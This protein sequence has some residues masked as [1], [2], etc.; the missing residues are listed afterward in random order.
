MKLKKFST[1]QM[2]LSALFIALI[3]VGAY[4]KVQ[5]GIIPFSLQMMFVFLTGQLLQPI[6]AAGTLAA[7]LF[8]G[9]IGLP[10]FSGGG[11]LGYVLQ[12]SFGYIPGFLVMAF[13][14]S[15]ISHRGAPSLLKN[16]VANVCGGVAVYL[17]GLG[18]YFCLN[19]FY[20][21]KVVELSKMLIYCWVIFIPSDM[22]AL[23]LTAFLGLRL[24]RYMPK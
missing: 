24:R 3:T 21:G 10:V 5:V 12:P 9:L 22:I 1:K 7:Y 13:L 6:W 14:I 8:M 23:V 11:G 20:F 15:V 4:L 18:Y 2:V 19:T 16:L 17:F